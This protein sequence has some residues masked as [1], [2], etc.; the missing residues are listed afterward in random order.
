MIDSNKQKN[1]YFFNF[2]SSLLLSDRS[3]FPPF[4]V[5]SRPLFSQAPCPSPHLRPPAFYSSLIV[6][7]CLTCYITGCLHYKFAVPLR[8]PSFK[9]VLA[10]DHQSIF[11]SW[12]ALSRK[13]TG[14]ILRGYRVHCSNYWNYHSQNVT[15]GPEQLQV[16]LTDLKP[17][18]YYEIY[19]AAFTS[20]GEGPKNWIL[21]K[22]RTRLK[23]L[24]L[25]LLL[26]L[27]L[28]TI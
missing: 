11:V 2:C 5:P 23:S 21:I 26:L 14:G 4:P 16:L 13:D 22:T 10:W 28:F 19:V 12:Y 8:E 20:K 24:L 6:L 7:N 25:F 27:L 9:S 1:H 18:T 15:V 17:D 3:R